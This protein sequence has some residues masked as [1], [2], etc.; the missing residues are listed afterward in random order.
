MAGPGKGFAGTLRMTAGALALRHSVRSLRSRG[1]RIVWTA[2]NIRPHN[3]EAPAVQVDLYR[4]LAQEADAVIVHTHYAAQLVRERLGRMGPIYLARHGNY[5]G[6]Y[7]PPGIDRK[8]LRA[9]YGFD[10]AD[11]VLLAFGQIRV[12]KQLLQLVSD[13]EA[14]APLATHLIIAGAPKDAD[15]VQKLKKMVAATDRV[16]LLDR[17]IPDSEVG[18]LYAL[19]DLAVFNYAEMFSSG[20]LMLAFSLGLAVLA[21]QLGAADELVGRPALFGWTTSPFEVLDD[22]L[23]VPRDVRK[24]TALATADIYGWADSARAHL[25]AYE[26]GSP[27]L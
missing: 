16:L 15:V 4:W 18:E 14:R 17:C 3:P 2:H 26:G 25:Q 8:A 6:V 19:A 11:H 21:P 23:S 24:R 13:F 27:S 12:Y 20:A 1:I 10:K 22:A 9:R 5:I 7:P